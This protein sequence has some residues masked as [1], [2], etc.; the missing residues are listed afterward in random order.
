M[1]VQIGLPWLYEAG[2]FAEPFRLRFH[3]WVDGEYRLSGRDPEAALIAGEALAKQ[4][5]QIT[6]S[7]ERSVWGQRFKEL[8]ANY[9]RSSPSGGP[10]SGT[11]SLRLEVALFTDATTGGGYSRTRLVPSSPTTQSGSI[12]P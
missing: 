8:L 6:D 10:M 7:G 3:D 5:V 1:V 9:A 2:R 11:V 12:H 4:L